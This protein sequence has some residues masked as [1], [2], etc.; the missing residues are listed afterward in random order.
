[1]KGVPRVTASAAKGKRSIGAKVDTVVHPRCMNVPPSP[2]IT[3]AFGND[4]AC[5]R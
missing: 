3:C 5:L 1:M 2:Q 4:A